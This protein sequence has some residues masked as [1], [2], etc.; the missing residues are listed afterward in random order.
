MMI[1]RRNVDR[2]GCG[3]HKE[4]SWNILITNLRLPYHCCANCLMNKSWE[5]EFLTMGTLAAKQKQHITVNP[6]HAS[7]LTEL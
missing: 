4:M 6:F 7:K 2:S 1:N 3:P 5:W